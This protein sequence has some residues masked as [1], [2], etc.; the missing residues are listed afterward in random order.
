MSTDPEN[1]SENSEDSVDVLGETLAAMRLT[2]TNLY[3]AELEAPWAVESP[4]Q[5]DLQAMFANGDDAARVLIFHAVTKGEVTMIADDGERFSASAGDICIF[6]GGRKHELRQGDPDR[7]MSIQ[8]L[9]PEPGATVRLGQTIT[10][11]MMCGCFVLRD[12]VLNPLLSALPN[13]MFLGRNSRSAALYEVLTSEFAAPGAGQRALLDR[14]AEMMFILA[15]R[16]VADVMDGTSWFR[17]VADPHVGRAIGRMHENPEADWTLDK[18]AA[19]AGVSRSGLAA[20]FRD[21]LGMPPGRYLTEWRMNLA[22][23][24]LHDR[25]LGLSEIAERV[26][27]TSEFAFSRAFKRHIGVAPSVWRKQER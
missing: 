17:A 2:G 24:L 18:L 12:T 1:L 10:A 15:V 21:T 13:V 9:T 25:A 14:A 11:G 22:T 26:G 8:E 4:C 20:R 7:R 5:A 23:R 3:R 19:V 6:A 27:Y 16:D